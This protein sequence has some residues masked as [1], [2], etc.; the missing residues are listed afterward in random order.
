MVVEAYDI[1][2]QNTLTKLRDSIMEPPDY[3]GKVLVTNP[4]YLSQ[5]KNKDKRAYLKYG[6]NDLYKCH[7]TTLYPQVEKGI[8]ILPSNFLSEA[9]ASARKMFFTNYNICKAKYFYYQV[10]PNATTGIVAFSFKKDASETKVFDIEVHY[11][12]R[13]VE[14][15][16]ELKPEYNY[17]YGQD[18]FDYIK[19]AS[20]LQ[21]TKYDERSKG[22]PNTNIVIGLL[23]YG[24]YS[25]GAHY[26]D[27][28]PFECSA[29]TFTTYQ[30]SVPGLK[31]SETKQRRVIERYNQVLF[32]HMTKYHGLF[33]ANYMGA[34][35]KIKSRKFS[36]LLLSKVIKEV[37]GLK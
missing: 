9:N 1:A 5:N 33:L 3:E 35:Q 21:I 25:M 18:F 36:N 17:L 19:D 14:D 8:L 32:D 34:E 4:P 28:K 31:L 2:P 24:K 26:N 27:G 37:T 7:L 30:V 10:F 22:R 13:I 29:T 16:I 23:S 11:K 20:P 6:Q 15:S 12:N